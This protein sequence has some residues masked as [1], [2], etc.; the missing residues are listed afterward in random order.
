MGTGLS[1]SN[2][3]G[4]RFNGA[5]PCQDFPV[6]LA[7]RQRKCGRQ[8]DYVCAEITQSLEQF[9]KADVVTN[10]AADGD[11]TDLVS[12][13]ILS[14]TDGVRFAID[15][16]LRGLYVE[17]VDLAVACDLFSIRPKDQ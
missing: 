16:A 6:I 3:I 17:K 15:D 14:T 9:W 7:G 5:C 1:D 10:A 12:H 2:K 8:N 13:N 11:V 4:L